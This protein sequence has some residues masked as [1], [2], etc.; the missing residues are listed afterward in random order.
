MLKANI[1]FTTSALEGASNPLE[2][3]QKH[4]KENSLQRITDVEVID[5]LKT[6]KGI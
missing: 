6:C 1:N 5:F 3:V 4:Y 2:M